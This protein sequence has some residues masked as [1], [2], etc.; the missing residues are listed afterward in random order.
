MDKILKLV[1]KSDNNKARM[2]S[3]YNPKDE[4]DDSG[5]NAA[6][7]EILASNVL[8]TSDGKA[9]LKHQAYLEAKEKQKFNII[10]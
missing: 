10:H 6:M 8:D 9:S 2:I 7:D 3:I 1:F 4:L 5:V